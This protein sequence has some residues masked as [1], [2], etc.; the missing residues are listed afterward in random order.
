MKRNREQHHP[1][2]HAAKKIFR[3][4]PDLVARLLE[5]AVSPLTLRF[6]DTSVP[7]RELR[8]DQV[9][10][11]GDD[12]EEN[13]FGWYLEFQA[14][15]NRREL[16]AWILKS[17]ALNS[18][19]RRPISLIVVYLQRC[20]AS[21]YLEVNAGGVLN[22]HE[23]V[24][25]RLWEFEERIRSGELTELAPF[26][27]LWNHDRGE[28]ALAEQRELLLNAPLP[29][30]IVEELMGWSVVVGSRFFPNEV[31]RRVFDKELEM[32]KDFPEVQRWMEESREEGVL[33][34]ARRFCKGNLRARFGALSPATEEYLDTRTADELHELAVRALDVSD[35]RSLGVPA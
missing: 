22:R 24:S 32:L 28:E 1:L 7:A 29:Y 16:S 34:T 27:I 8:A 4:A 15:E 2:D 5:L 35:L 31:L 6:A 30:E 9:L 14:G 3:L 25:I 26:L 21:D 10:L 12:G 11:F 20:A 17:A 33:Q 13:A 18:Q 23:F 19:L